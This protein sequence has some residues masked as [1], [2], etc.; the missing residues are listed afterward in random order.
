M[1]AGNRLSTAE[2]KWAYIGRV[3]D[4]LASHNEVTDLSRTELATIDEEWHV[5]T[6]HDFCA[7][8]IRIDRRLAGVAKQE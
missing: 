3:K 4:A 7:A 8:L 5:A 6:R 1:E 2:A